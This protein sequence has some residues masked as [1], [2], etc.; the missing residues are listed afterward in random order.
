[1]PYLDQVALNLTASVHKDLFAQAARLLNNDDGWDPEHDQ[2]IAELLAARINFP[3]EYKA[4]VLG[5]L[6]TIR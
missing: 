1:M 3:V 2:R 6:R 4:E 5:F